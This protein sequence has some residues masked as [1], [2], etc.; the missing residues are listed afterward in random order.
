MPEPVSAEIEALLKEDRSFAPTD[1][2][3]S[4]AVINDAAVYARAAKDPEAFWAAFA[5]ELEW[6]KPFSKVLEW[7][8]PEAKWF[9]DG[10]INVSA[11][12]LDRHVRTARRN[13]ADPSSRMSTAARASRATASGS[14]SRR[15][16]I[17]SRAIP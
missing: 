6:I 14:T 1:E 4:R 9:A 12:C 7:N 8:P 16:V 10:T 17:S 11:N 2:F 3:R 5:R 15:C 13:K